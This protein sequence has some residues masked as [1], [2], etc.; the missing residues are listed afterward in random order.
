MCNSNGEMVLSITSAELAKP[1]KLRQVRGYVR[2]VRKEMVLEEG[3]KLTIKAFK[4]QLGVDR[5]KEGINE[6]LDNDCENIN[7][8]VARDCSEL[9]NC[10]DCGGNNCGCAYC[11]SCN[12]CET[13]L[14]EEE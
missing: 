9:Y 3:T 12:A 8:E 4:S 11:F 14:G 2:N 10:C 1:G 7:C 6:I 13:C 5:V